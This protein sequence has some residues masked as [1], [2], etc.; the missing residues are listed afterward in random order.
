MQITHSSIE[1]AKGPADWFT[2]DVY[3][4]A[5]A[6]PAGSSTFAAANIHLC[7]A[8]APRGTP[9]RTGRRSSSPRGSGSASMRE[10]AVEVIRPGDRVFFEPG[11]NH[12][13]GAAPNRFM[14]HVAMNQNDDSG[15]PSHVGP[16]RH[17]R[18]IRGRAHHR[19]LTASR[20]TG[21]RQL[22]AGSLTTSS[23][24]GAQTSAGWSARVSL[25]R[26]R[27]KAGAPSAAGTSSAN[28]R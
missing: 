16:P 6:A 18:G 23:A 14:V 10:G 21:A 7:W 28:R 13:H 25:R 26:S 27:T 3:I 19:R 15:N 1:T 22:R 12:W 4:D 24:S 8:P 11:E 20:R 17:R 2:G 5:V 9:I